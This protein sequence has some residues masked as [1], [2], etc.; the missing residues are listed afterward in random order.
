MSE[1]DSLKVVIHT[2]ARFYQHV[3]IQYTTAVLNCLWIEFKM[4]LS[5]VNKPGFKIFLQVN[6]TLLDIYV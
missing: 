5:T 6:V 3:I 1:I 4:V 2:H